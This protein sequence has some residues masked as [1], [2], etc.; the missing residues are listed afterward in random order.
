[1]RRSNRILRSHDDEGPSAQ[2]TFDLKT[3]AKR[4]AAKRM[5]APSIKQADTLREPSTPQKT[6][7]A[8]GVSPSSAPRVDNNSVEPARASKG[9]LKRPRRHQL[10]RFRGDS[11]DIFD[12]PAPSPNT[13]AVERAVVA[14]PEPTAG[15][16]SSEDEASSSY[17][18]C[19]E[20]V[21]VLR[22][23]KKVFELS[24]VVVENMPIENIEKQEGVTNDGHDT[25]EEREH[26]ASGVDEEI[27]ET[28]QDKEDE[29]VD[30]VT[31]LKRPKGDS[32][33]NDEYELTN[34]DVDEDD[35][36]CGDLPESPGRTV[37][38]LQ[39]DIVKEKRD[40]AGSDAEIYLEYGL[41]DDSVFWEAS[42]T[43]D[44][45]KNWRD[46]I[47]EAQR[48]I[49]QAK[50][51]TVR[52]TKNL[53]GSISNGIDTYKERIYSQG[54]RQNF[55]SVETE[56]TFIAGLKRRVSQV[57]IDLYPYN[58]DLP[59]RIAKLTSAAYEVATDILPGMVGL[60]QWCLVAHYSNDSITA[61]GIDQLTQVLECLSKLCEAIQAESPRRN[62]ELA[63]KIRTTSVLV[64]F[65]SYVFQ[66]QQLNTRQPEI[67][68]PHGGWTR[69]LGQGHES[70]YPVKSVEPMVTT[71][72]EARPWSRVESETLFDA[73]RKYRG[74]ERYDLILLDMRDV[75]GHRS[76]EELR[77]KARETRAG[78]IADVTCPGPGIP[79]FFGSR[80]KPPAWRSVSRLTSKATVPTS[81]VGIADNWAP[82]FF[83]SVCFVL[84]IVP[85]QSVL[86]QE[87]PKLCCMTS[88]EDHVPA[89]EVVDAPVAA[90]EPVTDQ[91]DAHQSVPANIDSPP[92][93]E[94]LSAK[95]DMV[96][97]PARS[98]ASSTDPKR[99]LIASG[100]K[101]PSAAVS[102]RTAKPSATIA[103]RPTSGSTLN[104]PPIRPTANTAARKIPSSAASG[105]TTNV[106]RASRMSIGSSA[107]ERAKAI[108]SSGDE[109]RKSGMSGTAKRT[110]LSGTLG[111]RTTSRPST[112][113]TDRRSSITPATERKPATS[114]PSTATSQTPTKAPLRSTPT[115][116]TTPRT[117][118][119]IPTSTKTPASTDPAKRR[120]G[121]TASPATA[122][123][124][125]GAP[126]LDEGA[127]NDKITELETQLA[128]SEAKFAEA[129]AKIAELEKAGEDSSKHTE[130]AESY[131]QEIKV[132]Q[133]KLEELEAKYEEAIVQSSK[134]VEEAKREATDLGESKSTEAL[135]LQRAEHDV[136]L[137]NLEADLAT[138]SE[139]VAELTSKIDTL[140]KDLDAATKQVE[141]S[142]E[143]E[144][145]A[146]AALQQKLSLLEEELSSSKKDLE[147]AQES[148]SQ[149]AAKLEEKVASLEK[150][151]EEAKSEAEKGSANTAEAV[152]Q[153]EAE[154]KEL[155]AAIEAL[156]DDIQKAH[157]SKTDELEQ[158]R[159][160]FDS[161]HDRSL[162]G[163]KADHDRAMAEMAAG[164]DV[165]V[166]QLSAQHKTERSEVEAASTTA[167]SAL[168]QE[169][170][171]LTEKHEAARAD[172]NKKIEDLT[173][174]KSSLSSQV[175]NSQSNYE[176]EIQT[177][178]TKL[179]E[180]EQALASEK[181]AA[182]KRSADETA[183]GAEIDTLKATIQ[184]LEADLSEQKSMVK[185]LTA[186]VEA[187][188]A[189]V[190][191]LQKVLEA[192][193]ADSK[194]KDEHHENMNKK[195]SAEIETINKSLEEKTQEITSTKQ[196]H[197]EALEALKTAHAAELAK[198]E[199]DAATWQDK[200]K[201]LQEEQEN[202]RTLKEETEKTHGAKIE[203]L[204][205]DHARQIEEHTA[206][207]A[208]LSETH[209]ANE[210]SAKELEDSHAKLKEEF[211][212]TLADTK[213]NLES[214]HAKGVEELLAAHEEKLS[215]LKA[216]HDTTSA[217]KLAATEK[218]H[219]KAVAELQA[220]LDKAK[221]AAADT[222][223]IDALKAEIA[224]LK[225]SHASQIDTLANEKA[226]LEKKVDS[227]GATAKDAETA[228]EDLVAKHAEELE[229]AKA[230]TAKHSD[231]HAAAVL[232][233][234]ALKEVATEKETHCHESEKKFSELERD[235]AALSEKNMEMVE[236]IQDYEATA[237]KSAR[238]IRELEFDLKDALKSDAPTLNGS[239]KGKPGLGASK[240]AT[241]EDEEPAKEEADGKQEDSG[242]LA[243]EGEKL[244]SSI[245]GTMASIQEQLRQLEGVS[246][247]MVENRARI[248]NALEQ[249]T[250]RMKSGSSS[251]PISSPSNPTLPNTS[252]NT[253]D[254]VAL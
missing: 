18:D 155:N 132:L 204:E 148:S 95:E 109:S 92:R 163:L 253:N 195:L 17:D 96:T 87:N 234:K 217:E 2:L 128:A 215:N 151:L 23:P 212:K 14:K 16:E 187:E 89:D 202:L 167:K 114:R 67:T 30:L 152:L 97:S 27:A 101:R 180:A 102:T 193:E 117:T 186:D 42:K 233:I 243:T 220:N 227:V 76:A 244:G 247:E 242:P 36:D 134:D 136:A 171:N 56:Q 205:A 144:K 223:S 252:S 49:K 84:C 219:S 166:A 79:S 1:M 231:A 127:E 120:I 254:I 106:A 29:P 90:E 108:A 83:F 6:S 73:L 91:E 184:S 75:L 40:I 250:Q 12:V 11:E 131:T 47:L 35:D 228:R 183:A 78:F 142:K 185:S 48:L 161:T 98:Q 245:A 45:E 147:S 44:Q 125:A 240:W 99:S 130:M 112:A 140:S 176:T 221:E 69:N 59:T 165:H 226:E 41:R 118:R 103:G 189:Q 213:E 13:D 182:E 22:T 94:V 64:R 66:R 26:E 10:Q 85:F 93:D 126:A 100:P 199:S 4:S 209:K 107:D 34:T 129:Q 159:A 229:A 77:E 63:D 235:M 143:A 72:A 241:T 80:S 198:H 113:S 43:F 58:A 179:E 105:A 33:L 153:K 248:I 172:L 230:E 150:Q 31:N 24:A 110:S 133:G 38:S 54:K 82:I 5:G 207:F 251:P 208:A 65:M 174:E 68:Q 28:D 15:A 164:H 141:E 25:L 156:Q 191:G 32:L 170:Q 21:E 246:D 19:Q 145:E 7:Q 175:E 162:A 157:Q 222:S 225:A 239:S 218:K 51:L 236:K 3:I 178:K 111:S 206:K 71:H 173:A 46:L 200:I 86:T 149:N 138:K 211:E 190:T 135:S 62:T 194:D 8:A 52:S 210:S 39:R 201:G 224:E 216:E 192:F 60:L 122:R 196:E 123:R 137:K 168:E 121:A 181:L 249:T 61:E 146:T 238:K 70:A 20:V 119:T 55:H 81:A 158:L 154:I 139:A 115:S 74:P 37:I 169:L 124:A 232:E 9:Q 104:K 197:A 57:L 50:G 88:A 188:R 203:A 214:T 160:E 177:L 53:F 237:A 116:S